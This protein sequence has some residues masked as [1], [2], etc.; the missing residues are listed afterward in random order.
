MTIKTAFQEIKNA[1]EKIYEIREAETIAFWLFENVT[2]LK[3]WEIRNEEKQISPEQYNTILSHLEKLLL[4]TPI[5]YVLHEAWFYKRKFYVDDRVLIPR[6]ETEELVEWIIKENKHQ[7]ALQILDIG[8]GSG[9]IPISLKKE[10][11]QASFTSLDVS[12]GAIEVAKKNAKSLDAKISFIQQDFLD[13]D[14][15]K[16]L[17]IFDLIVSNPPYIPFA[18]KEILDKN[19]VNFEPSVALFVPDQNP[20]IFYEKIAAFAVSHLSRKGTIY[21]EVHEDYAKNVQ[22]IFESK[23]FQTQTRKDL[24]G[25]ERMI[26]S[27]F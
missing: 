4:H 11:P 7:P 24:Y 13:S 5:Q 23:G 22:I 16:T 25:K 18:D 12:D 2:A 19:V 9:C 20:F 1:L 15:W 26:K 21:V 3:K 14:S 27:H 10:L 8:T 17:P 6:P